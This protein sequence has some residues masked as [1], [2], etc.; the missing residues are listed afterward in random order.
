MKNRNT[1]IKRTETTNIIVLLFL[2]N[3]SVR[4]GGWYEN[5][6]PNDSHIINKIACA[7]FEAKEVY[8]VGDNGTFAFSKDGGIIWQVGLVP[9]PNNLYD[10]MVTHFPD[11][12]VIAVGAGGTVL[13]SVDKGETWIENNLGPDDLYSVAFDGSRVWIAGDNRDFIFSSPDLGLT[14]ENSTITDGV[15]SVNKLIPSMYGI[16]AAAVQG[17]TTYILAYD[18]GQNDFDTVDMI[19]DFILKSGFEEFSNLYFAGYDVGTSQAAIV[20]KND[21]GGIYGP[22]MPFNPAGIDFEITAINGMLDTQE[23]LWIATNDG[24]I[25]Q[26]DATASNFFPVYQNPAGNVVKTIAVRPNGAFNQIAWAGGTQGLMLRYDFGVMFVT[27]PQNSFIYPT[28]NIIQIRFTSKP[29]L[30]SIQRGIYIHSSIK[31]RVHFL[32][33]YAESDSNMVE[34]SL[35]EG[36]IPGEILTMILSDFVLEEDSPATI[37]GF[38]YNLNVIPFGP[39]DFNFNPPLGVHTINAVSTNYVTGFFNN[40]DSFDLITFARDTLFCFA[41]DGGS[42]FLAVEKIALGPIIGVNSSI[43]QQLKVVDFNNDSRL[44][45]VLFDDVRIQNIINNSDVTFSFSLG[46]YYSANISDIDFLSADNDSSLD[47]IILSDSLEIRTGVNDNSF[48]SK[49]SDE[50]FTGWRKITVGDID[51]DGIVDIAAI[52]ASNEIVL[53]HGL[54][55]GGFDLFYTI[56]GAFREVQLADINSDHFLDVL[57]MDDIDAV[58]VFKYNPF[59]SFNPE[60]SITQI[61]PNPLH[62]FDVYDYNG[63]GF[64]D[65]ILATTLK[66]IKVFENMSGSGFNELPDQQHIMTINPTGLLHGDFDKDGLLDLAA[67]DKSSGDFQVILKTGGPLSSIFFDTIEVKSGQVHLSWHDSNMPNEVGFYRIYRD[68]IPGTMNILADVDTTFYIDSSVIPGQIYWYKVEAFDLGANSM[69]M[70]NE[71]EV[72]VYQEISGPISGVLADIGTAYIVTAPIEVSEGS[73]LQI[74]PGVEL[75]FENGADFRVYGDLEVMGTEKDM[76]SFMTDNEQT[77][78]PGILISGLVNTDTVRMSWFDIHRADQALRI[79]NRPLKVQYAGITENGTAFDVSFSGGFLDAQNILLHS[80]TIGIHAKSGSKV[81]LK[82]TTIARNINEGIV[83]E[84]PATVKISNSII[85]DN[86]SDLLKG[87]DIKSTSLSASEIRYSTVDS[88]EGNFVLDNIS[89]IPPLFQP[90][91]LDTMSFSPDT[92]SATI[93]AGDPADDFRTEPMPN[94]GRINQGVYGGTPFATPT[95]QAKF[96]L[97]PDTMK[98]AAALSNTDTKSMTLYNRGT[99]DLRVNDFKLLA[100]EFSYNLTFPKIIPPGDSSIINL[101]FSPSSRTTVYDHLYINTNDP[102]FPDPGLTVMLEG[103]GLNRAPVSNSTLTDTL[104]YTYVPFDF[105]FQVND[106]D[107]DDLTFSDNSSL[108]DI[109][110]TLGHITFTPTI[111]DTGKHAIA[112]TV[113]DGFITISDTLNLTIA[114]NPVTSPQGLTVTPG[115]QMLT[116]TWTNPDNQFYSGTIICMSHLQAINDADSALT[117]LDTILSINSTVQYSIKNLEIAK[118]YYLA[119]FNYFDPGIHIYSHALQS[120]ATTLAPNVLFDF[121]DHRA[122]V[123][124][125]DTLHAALKVINQGG[126]TLYFR[127]SY[128]AN[129]I[130]DRWFQMDTTDKS[131]APYDS[132]EVSFTMNPSELMNDID[133]NVFIKLETNQ[134]GWIVRDKKIIMKILFDRIAPKITTLAEPDSAHKFAAVRFKFTANDTIDTL[135]WSIGDASDDLRMKYRFLKINNLTDFDVLYNGVDLPIAPIDFYPLEDGL[136]RFD[137]WVYDTKGNGFADNAMAYQ[138]HVFVMGSTALLTKHRWYLASIPRDHNMPLSEFFIDSSA[139]IF[140]WDNNEMKYI[141][142]ADSTLKS[143]QGVWILSF[144]PRLIDVKKYKLNSERDSSTVQLESGW[145]QIGV[146]SGYPLHFAKMRFQP[147]ANEMVISISEAIEQKLIA[148]AVYWYRSS[149]LLPGYEWGILDSTIAYPW[150]GYWVYAP[151]GGTLIFS[152]D[153]AFPDR[154]I[155]DSRSDNV[156]ALNKMSNN[157]WRLA[158]TIQNDQHSDAGN[159]IGSGYLT[160]TLP[161]YE[162]PHLSEHC[163]AYFSTPQGKITQDIREPFENISEVKEW[164]L[165]ISTSAVGKDHELSWPDWKE[166]GGVYLYLV[167]GESE[168]VLNMSETNSYHFKTNTQNRQFT[169]YA[170]QDA[171]F[172]PKIIPSTFK[173]MQNYPN[174]FNPVTTIKF[175]IPGNAEGQKISLKIYNILGQE[176]LSLLDNRELSP[177]YHEVSWDG[178]NASGLRVASGIYFYRLVSAEH[179]FVRKMVMLK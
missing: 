34:L 77:T 74:M 103:T 93:D 83:V 100:P 153:P 110:P 160:Q 33:S 177:G 146:P 7:D 24:Y 3:I 70:S 133:H 31:G 131:I 63:D 106:L 101:T 175:G 64:M 114:L 148:P 44:D 4:G 129:P 134:P 43:E 116:L 23:Q 69:G 17:N 118:T 120:T 73:I 135:G 91:L 27:P 86:N 176:I 11:T 66:E 168:K 149:Y 98:F 136:Y 1:F 88:L 155:S 104:I 174:P 57:A 157:N 68:I 115:D 54:P 108:F 163:S 121:S 152:Y 56:P 45:L 166:D 50:A 159:I 89:K 42:G 140:R 173:L 10:I 147:R 14:W 95:F 20:I 21:Q 167:D 178:L 164:N 161:I 29:V 16:Y 75:M 130:L 96:A 38:S 25:Y 72:R 28:Q 5:F 144:K 49:Y 78:W 124:P 145:N 61:D 82:N 47:F 32:P 165:K 150:R 123:P 79:E 122:Y 39:S 84:N 18:G 113:N 55:M 6:Y 13:R 139:A 62:A 36:G 142:F 102:H 71:I 132:S 154:N 9:T 169:I 143:G 94:G 138:K 128:A 125:Q 112:I 67:F 97:K 81:N 30:E 60:G 92:L 170:T 26:S 151:Q 48:G 59:W 51:C 171:N 162:P 90:I 22:A 87:P 117:I 85:W 12:V 141:S 107:G 179:Q 105:T 41:G 158:L 8:A 19:P 65:V 53:S 137:L 127:F 40:D 58:H 80:N 2:L 119:I 172:T 156:S 111:E 109:D 46:D 15:M 76:V 35:L 126:G 99:V 37:N 52:N